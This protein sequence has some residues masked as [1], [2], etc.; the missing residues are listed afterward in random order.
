MGSN[1]CCCTTG[2]SCSAARP[3]SPAASSRNAS[4]G[5]SSRFV[6]LTSSALGEQA[7]R[8]CDVQALRAHTRAGVAGAQQSRTRIGL[9]DGC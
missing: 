6:S 1:M 8:S 9:N 3:T 4:G 5:S 7:A 2:C